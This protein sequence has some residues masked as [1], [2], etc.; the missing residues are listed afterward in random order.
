MIEKIKPLSNLGIKFSMDDFG[1][2]YSSLSYLRELSLDELKIDKSFID[3]LETTSEGKSMV[4]TILSFA[5]NL[6]MSV[7]AEGVEEAAQVEFLKE[8][9]CDVLQGYY[10]SKPILKE[11]FE[12]FI[13]NQNIEV[14]R[15]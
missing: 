3:E 10:F 11:E 13:E 4:K 2:G 9:G 1:T 7:V 14:I 15:A 12:L 6:N 5:R 8:I